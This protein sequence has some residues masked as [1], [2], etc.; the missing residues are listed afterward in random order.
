MRIGL[1]GG[2]FNPIHNG[3]IHIATYVYQTLSLDQMIF[4]PT[5]DPPHKPPTSLAPAHHR[6]E[7][8][9][10]AI[11][12]YKNFT[13]DDQEVK[14]STISYSVDTV[15]RLKNTFSSGTEL[16]FIIGLDAFLDFPSWKQA[17]HLLEMCHMTVCSR[18]G[19]SFTQLQSM[20]LLPYI[21]LAKLQNLDQNTSTCLEITLASGSPITF[22]SAPPRNVSA[23][24]IR[25]QIALKRPIGQWLPP[26]V[27]SY[28]IEHQVYQ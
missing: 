28:I 18:P 16:N 1:L 26:S 7:M 10:R 12:S 2:S 5:G 13:V 19:V 8:V 21:P 11:K 25:K 3:H 14:S 15:T 27:E 20:K 17:N 24:H 23:S 6:L 9:R 4:I 22:L